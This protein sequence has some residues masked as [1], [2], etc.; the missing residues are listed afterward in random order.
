MFF[1]F[2]KIEPA[3][4]T[5]TITIPYHTL[6][7]EIVFENVNFEYPSRP[8][9]SVINNLNLKIAAGETVALCGSSGSGILN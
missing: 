8:F 4:T 3:N 5:G 2:L 9:Y 1:Q 6:L 7:G